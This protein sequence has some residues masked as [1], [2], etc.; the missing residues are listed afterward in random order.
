MEAEPKD[1]P[2]QCVSQSQQIGP[3]L[4]MAVRVAMGVLLIGC[5]DTT[6]PDAE[7]R[8]E[9]IATTITGGPAVGA[10]I[11]GELYIGDCATGERRQRVQVL[12]NG[13][14]RYSVP[15]GVEFTGCIRLSASSA[16]GSGM[17]EKRGVQAGGGG[18]KVVAMDITLNAR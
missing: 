16:Q 13:N 5:G 2:R 6:G 14:G 12:S 8:V 1:K 3:A 9:G 18:L 11:T 7:F 17:I 15:F 4:N 10:T